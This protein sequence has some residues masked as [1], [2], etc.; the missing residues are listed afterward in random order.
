MEIAFQLQTFGDVLVDG[1][2]HGGVA[3]FIP[4]KQGGRAQGLALFGVFDEVVVRS[5]VLGRVANVFQTQ[6]VAGAA[7]LAR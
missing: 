5:V 1:D 4:Q 3:V 7:N 6:N 2:A